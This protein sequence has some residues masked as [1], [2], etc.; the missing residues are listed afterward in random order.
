MILQ[1]LK[2][3]RLLAVRVMV[4]LFNLRLGGQ[5]NAGPSTAEQTGAEDLL[6]AV[7]D[8]YESLNVYEFEG[9]ETAS[10]PGTKCTLEVPIQLAAA[11][12]TRNPAIKFHSARPSKDCLDE[13]AKFGSLGIPGEW[14]D[15]NNM[16]IGVTAVKELASRILSLPEGNV[17]CTVLEV[18][19]DEY[20]RKLRSYDG[21][22]TYWVDSKTDLVRG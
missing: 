1:E 3:Q 12:P 21:P 19:Y 5:S 11:L 8:K 13:I 20:H 6:R 16:G 10:V 18:F 9:I 14:S 22:V 4:L 2:C 15:F 17:R 7:S